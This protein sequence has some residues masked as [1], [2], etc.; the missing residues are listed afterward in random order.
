M[1]LHRSCNAFPDPPPSACFRRTERLK[2]VSG[3]NVD[4]HVRQKTNELKFSVIMYVYP[5]SEENLLLI[6][7]S[8]LISSKRPK[9]DVWPMVRTILKRSWI[10]LVVLKSPWVRLRSLKSACL[11][12]LIG[13]KKS[14]KLTTCLRQTPFCVKLDYFV[15]A[16]LA[17]PGCKNL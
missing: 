9:L 7:F 16:N 8:Y 6:W 10:L 11:P 4:L 3:T 15:E 5:R 17:N 1:S 12:S 13:L 2:I 14:L